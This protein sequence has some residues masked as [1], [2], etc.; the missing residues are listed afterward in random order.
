MT[1][2]ERHNIDK[3]FQIEVLTKDLIEMLMEDHGMTM[4][5]AMDTLYKSHTY[6]LIEREETGLYY[7]GAVYVM[8]F[9]AEELNAKCEDSHLLT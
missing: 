6:E 4:Q 3:Q 9:L 1:A 8:S 5:Q 7:Q 2:E